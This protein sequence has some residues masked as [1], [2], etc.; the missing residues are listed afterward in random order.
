LHDG[1]GAAKWERDLKCSG[2]A[3]REKHGKHHIT[4]MEA[5]KGGSREGHETLQLE[6][7]DILQEG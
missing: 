1:V 2:A 5:S 7:I 6:R 4:L 3:F